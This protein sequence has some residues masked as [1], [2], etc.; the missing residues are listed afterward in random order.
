[1]MLKGKRTTMKAGY[2]PAAEVISPKAHWTLIKVLEDKGPG[3]DSS[4]LALGF[5][6]RKPYLAMRWN[7]DKN[8][9]IGNPQSR[10]LPTWFMIPESYVEGILQTLPRD[11]RAFARNFFEEPQR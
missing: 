9:P 10:G 4:S 1:M 6:D 7:G 11:Q 3:P 5:W 2:K 8:N